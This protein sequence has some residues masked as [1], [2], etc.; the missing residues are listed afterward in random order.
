MIDRRNYSHLLVLIVVYIV[1]EGYL[2]FCSF[3]VVIIVEITS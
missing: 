1:I 3:R 2:A